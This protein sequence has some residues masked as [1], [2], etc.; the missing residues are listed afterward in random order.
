MVDYPY[1]P[2]LSKLKDVLSKIRSLGVPPKASYKWLESLGYKSTNDRTILKV[3]RFIQ[4]SDS[5]NRPTELWQQYRGKDSKI[6]MAQGI[7]QG[8]SELFAIYPDAHSRNQSELEHFF[9][10][11]TKGGQQVVSKIVSTF[12]TLCEMANFNHGI[13]LQISSDGKKAI[14]N[15]AEPSTAFPENFQH[16]NKED[17]FP[18]YF[19]A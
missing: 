18:K 9:S 2:V 6:I 10:T 15:I 17:N 14:Q 1:A 16:S 13:E 5:S 11:H 4:F 8:Y 19:F 3:L 7:K 12:K